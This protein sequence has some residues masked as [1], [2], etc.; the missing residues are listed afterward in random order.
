MTIRSL[1]QIIAN[2][3][4]AGTAG[5]QGETL[6]GC[7]VA[8]EP[9][10]RIELPDGRIVSV[11]VQSVARR[12]DTTI[13]IGRHGYVFARP[14]TPSSLP[15][16]RDSVIG[17]A[18]GP[19]KDA[20]LVMTPL[21]SKQ[22]FFPTVGA[23]ADGFH[24]VFATS[25]DSAEIRPGMQDSSTIWY[26]RYAGGRW[27]TPERVLTTGRVFLDPESTSSVLIRGDALSFA[28]PFADGPIDAERGGIILLRRRNGAW[29]ADT[30]RTTDVPMAVR[31][32]YGNDESLTVV[33]TLRASATGL[34]QV[35]FA[36][37]SSTWSDWH[38]IA[39]REVGITPPMLL[40]SEGGFIASWNAVNL[41]Q[42]EG[43]T[44]EWVR[45]GS[46][47][48]VAQRPAV[49]FGEN[50][51]PFE[52]VVLE[53]RNPVWLYHG[54]PF[55]TSVAVTSASA[56]GAVSLGTIDVPFANPRARS[57]ALDGKRLMAFTM[58][59]GTAPDEPV[60]A[61][62]VT[63]IEFRCPRSARR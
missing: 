29:S 25:S 50:T 1:I 30:L 35:A 4:A 27:T 23:G 32:Q 6:A 5:A 16:M 46:D 45:L 55:G 53:N 63:V 54:T 37:F 57:I 24:V 43:S 62:Y 15:L 2:L 9:A 21:R 18:I 60:I 8:A 31:A 52:L 36:R 51:Y 34:G 12:G 41:S 17:F 47:G 44:I 10:R 59:Q 7:S 49:A 3:L 26:A 38:A 48:A 11:D 22:V 40:A 28:F 61:S 56:L 14:T 33:F 19:D 58:K 13:A 39:E 42:L 20:S